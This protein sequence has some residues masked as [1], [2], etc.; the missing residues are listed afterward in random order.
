MG[1]TYSFKNARDLLE[2][3]R[4][5]VARLDKEV[6]GDNFFNLVITAYHIV[7][8]VEND[9]SLPSSARRAARIMKRN[10]HIAICH[11]ITNASKHF[12]LDYTPKTDSAESQQGLGMGRLGF[13]GLGVGEEQIDIVCTDGTQINSLELAN[14]VLATWD[15]FFKKH[16][17]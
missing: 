7:D 10:K 3:L 13:G 8:W 5:E 9:T 4:R 6:T 1:L 12:S 16:G 11:D 17:I 2:K 15:A 14:N